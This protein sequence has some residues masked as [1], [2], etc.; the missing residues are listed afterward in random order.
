MAKNTALHRAASDHRA[1]IVEILLRHGADVEIRDDNGETALHWAT[2]GSLNNVKVVELLLSH[3]ADVNAKD[4]RGWTALDWAYKAIDYWY[5]AATAKSLDVVAL[6][7][8]YGADITSS[9]IGREATLSVAKS[10]QRTDI[11]EFLPMSNYDFL[12]LCKS[13]NVQKIE[14]AL[15]KGADVNA[16]D[17]GGKTALMAAASNGHTETAEVLLKHG[18]DVNAKSNNGYTAL[19]WATWYGHTETADLLRIYGATE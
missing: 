13:G 6:L 7:L 18:A 17:F 8:K 9:V 14:E 10:Y 2:G 16:M 12:A 11:M 5:Y 3:G 1:D 19:I 15:V 4:N